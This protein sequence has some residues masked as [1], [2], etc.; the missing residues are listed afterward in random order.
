MEPAAKRLAALLGTVGMYLRFYLVFGIFRR[1]T[2]HKLVV[3]SGPAVNN[4]FAIGLPVD[5]ECLIG[6]IET[7]FPNYLRYVVIPDPIIGGN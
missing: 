7:A 1:P 2:C 3:L 5:L 6:S 4:H